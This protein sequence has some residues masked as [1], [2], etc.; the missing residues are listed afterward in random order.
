[1]VP[2]R[3]VDCS[4]RSEGYKFN[5]EVECADYTTKHEIDS[6]SE[7]IISA[8]GRLS[9]YNDAVAQ[10]QETFAIGGNTLVKRLHM[11]NKLKDYL[12]DAHGKFP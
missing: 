1:M 8:I 2:P 6:G 7:V 11:D 9:D 10:L 12:Y 3:D 5:V 4:F